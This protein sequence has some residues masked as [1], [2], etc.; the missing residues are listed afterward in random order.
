[1]AGLSCYQ[2]GPAMQRHE[3][4]DDR[5]DR[6]KDMLPGKLG[7]PEVRAKDNRLFVNGM[8]WIGKSGPVL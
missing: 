2:E 4:S 6:M 3:I 5:W 7:D 1:M 8:S